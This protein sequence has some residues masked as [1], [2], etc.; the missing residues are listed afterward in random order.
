M[1]RT[2]TAV[3]LALLLRVPGYAGWQHA[4]WGYRAE[5]QVAAAEAKEN[6]LVEWEVDFGALL[7]SAGEQGAFD[8]NSPR[9]TIVAGGAEKEAPCRFFPDKDAAGRGRLCWL[10]LGAMRAGAVDTCYVYFDAGAAKPA[11]AYPEMEMVQPVMKPN[12]L[13]NGD[14][15]APDEKNNAQPKAWAYQAQQPA[16]NVAWTQAGGRSS[17]AFLTL[18][19]TAGGAT[20]VSAA[21]TVPV[22]PDTRYAL[23][24][25]IKVHKDSQGGHAGLTAWFA[26][27]DGKAVSGPDGAYGNY[28]LQ[29]GMAAKEET[30]WRYACGAR[31]NVYD[32]K[33]KTNR[34]TEGDKTLA[35][36]GRA[37]VELAMYY[38][39]ATA[40]FT[41]VALRE[42]P[43][44]LPIGIRVAAV[45]KR[46]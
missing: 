21:Q 37:A 46:P 19:N 22:A 30:A 36:T 6:P 12:L 29:V 25:W 39:K 5:L 11:K 45:E 14:L 1:I 32:P 43:E 38:G 8:A 15:S 4:D 34:A 18:T 28:K 24:G 33:T 3:A 20:G 13:T 9:V 16:G 41:I 17:A 26:S 35:G 27:A 31:L 40:S 7:K 10:R 44:G 2:T 42:C 23:S